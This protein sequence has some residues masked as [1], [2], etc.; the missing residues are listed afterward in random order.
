M[1]YFIKLQYTSSKKYGKI[2]F[3][4]EL[5]FSPLSTYF[6]L[7]IS[8]FSKSDY[9]FTTHLQ[10]WRKKVK[11]K[12]WKEKRFRGKDRNSMQNVL[13]YLKKIRRCTVETDG[14]RRVHQLKVPQRSLCQLYHLLDRLYWW[15]LLIVRVWQTLELQW[16]RQ[17][18]VSF[19][20]SKFAI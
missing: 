2:I 17:S 4:Y 3:Q 15:S 9:A 1:M 13:L 7:S 5:K 8:I 11:K 19:D 20:L 18:L 14:F 12:N 16:T 10:Y 6:Y